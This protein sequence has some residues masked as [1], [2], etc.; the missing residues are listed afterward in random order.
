ML[1]REILDT[2]TQFLVLMTC[3]KILGLSKWFLCIA[4]A[5]YLG[6]VVLMLVE[7]SEE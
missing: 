3:I 2:F 1:L 7:E 6:M 4:A 5:L